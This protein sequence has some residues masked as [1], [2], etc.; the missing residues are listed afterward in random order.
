MFYF[1]LGQND[2]VLDHAAMRKALNKCWPCVMNW[3]HTRTTHRLLLVVLLERVL[4]YLD[5]PIL[6]TDFLMDSLDVG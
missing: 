4:P 1:F 3:E 5:K 2:L 6:L